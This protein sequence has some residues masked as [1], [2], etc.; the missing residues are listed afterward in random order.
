MYRLKLVLTSVLLATMVATGISAAKP[1]AAEAA[2]N[3]APKCGGGKI[4]L[5]ATEKA[6]FSLHNRA[7]T[8]RGLKAL[9]V[10]PALQRAA[11]GHSA[12]MIKNDYFAH[13]NV[14][15]RLNRF[16]YRWRTYGEN[17]A[18]GSGSKAAPGY[19]FRQW[20]NSSSH[21]P[22]ILGRSFREVGIGAVNGNYKGINV[23]MYTVDFGARR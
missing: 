8:S 1:P 14:G 10:H 5:T 23:T 16:G 18:Y 7:R 2:S 4:S 12:E 3:Y 15:Q 19:I 22:N 21:R 20:M 9:C 6:S 11:R 17:I 13:G